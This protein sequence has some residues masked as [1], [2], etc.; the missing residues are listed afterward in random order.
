[1]QITF[2]VEVNGLM[3][4]NSARRQKKKHR[5]AHGTIIA[6]KEILSEVLQLTQFVKSNE[7]GN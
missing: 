3:L 1:M 4:G 2:E 6:L 7:L 5:V